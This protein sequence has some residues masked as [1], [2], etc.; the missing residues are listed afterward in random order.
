MKGKIISKFL[1]LKLKMCSLV[2]VNNEEIKKAKS[3]N[4]NVAKI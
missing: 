2:V 4:K 3:V 1:G